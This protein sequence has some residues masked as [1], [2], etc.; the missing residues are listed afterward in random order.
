MLCG[1]LLGSH[2]ASPPS[3]CTVR[4]LKPSPQLFEHCVKDEVILCKEIP[5]ASQFGFLFA[6]RYIIGEGK[7]VDYACI[8]LARVTAALSEKKKNRR[9]RLYCSCSVLRIKFI[10]VSQQ[11][12]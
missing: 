1:L 11:L 4:L 8:Q 6:N 3:H 10:S 2:W 12:K 5:L 7:S 9:E